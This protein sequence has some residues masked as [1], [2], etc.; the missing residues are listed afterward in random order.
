MHI[1]GRGVLGR[2]GPNHTATPIIT[3]WARDKLGGVREVEGRRV[4]ETV[5]VRS[6][7]G[8]ALPCELVVPG[9]RSVLFFVLYYSFYCWL[10][11]HYVDVFSYECEWVL[12]IIIHGHV[13]SKLSA[14]SGH[15][16]ET[17]VLYIFDFRLGLNTDSGWLSVELLILPHWDISE[18][19]NK[20]F[21]ST[22]NS[23]WF[24]DFQWMMVQWLHK[25]GLRN[26]ESLSN[27]AGEK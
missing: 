25:V 20:D 8:W 12:W 23:I 6:R 18:R 2:W 3:R 26:Q 15:L 16:R 1:L 4:L 14:K 17:K 9:D 11:T 19:M 10:S 22:N 5:A 27:G 21:L 13:E 24:I 7:T